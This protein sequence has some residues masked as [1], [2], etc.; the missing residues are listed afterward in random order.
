[1]NR[2]MAVSQPPGPTKDIAPVIRVPSVKKN[3][4]NFFFAFP[5]SASAP[6]KGDRNATMS[7]ETESP[8][9]RR[10]VL[11][12]A[13]APV[14][15][16]DLK[17]KGKNAVNTTTANAEFAQSYMHQHAAARRFASVNHLNRTVMCLDFLTF[18]LFDLWT[19]DCPPCPYV[20]F[21][22]FSAAGNST[23][24]RMS[25]YPGEFLWSRRSVGLSYTACWYASGS[26]PPKKANCPLPRTPCM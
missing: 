7:P 8:M 11:S 22:F 20:F 3:N 12:A 2:M 16:Y 26:C 15:Q 17:R 21:S 1:M 14:S 19:S 18:G 24:L 4:N 9:P 6:R 25:R 13:S 5:A 10:A 23:L